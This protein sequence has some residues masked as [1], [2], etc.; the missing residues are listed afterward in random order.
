MVHGDMHACNL[1]NLFFFIVDHVD[2]QYKEQ[3]FIIC[4]GCKVVAWVIGIHE[5]WT[6]RCIDNKFQSISLI[7]TNFKW[8]NIH[9]SWLMTILKLDKSPKHMY[10]AN[11]QYQKMIWKFS[12]SS[13]FV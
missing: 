11:L 5:N 10:T 4:S 6:T 9:V 3:H 8:S 2:I 1:L 13:M 7:S 12:Y